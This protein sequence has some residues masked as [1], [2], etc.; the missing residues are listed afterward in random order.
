MHKKARLSFCFFAGNHITKK[1]EN[2]TCTLQLL[3]HTSPVQVGEGHPVRAPLGRPGIPKI[4]QFQADSDF[5]LTG[6][7]PEHTLFVYFDLF[8]SN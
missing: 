4:T 2:L 6:G 7:L 5:F 8:F 1:K 3:L